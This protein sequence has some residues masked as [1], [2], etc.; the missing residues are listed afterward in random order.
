M[1]LLHLKMMFDRLRFADNMAIFLS[2]AAIALGAATYAAL[3]RSPFFG[4]DLTTVRILLGLDMMVLLALGTLVT[5]KIWAI[6]SR[7]RR[8][9]AASRLHIRVVSVFTMLAAAPAVLVAMFAAIFFYFGVEAWFSERVSTALNESQAVARAYL[10][11]HQQVLRADALSMAND[12][13]RQ[14][15][16]LSEDPVR[17]AQAVSAQAYLRSLTEVIVFDGSGK[18]LARSGLTFA[19]SFEPITDEMRERARQGEVVLVISDT[20][21]RV[22]ALVRLDNFVDTYLFV[23]RL[24]EPKVLNHME[25]TEKAVEEYRDL[26][27][28]SSGIRVMI[29]IIFVIVALLL[30]LAAVWFGLSF[31]NTLVRPISALIGATNRVRGGDLTARVEE[32]AELNSDDELELLGRGFNRM[33]QQIESQRAELMEANRQLDLRRRFTEAVLSGVSAGVIGLDPS[34]NITMMNSR[35]MEFFQL[36]NADAL[37]GHPLSVLSPEIDNH[38]RTLPRKG[39]LEDGQVEIRR[40]GQSSRTILV[41]LSSELQGGETSGYVLT[42][43][44]VS[45]LVNAQRKAAWA[46]V[47][48]RIAHEI[49]NP[50]TPIQL[51]AERLRRKYLKEIT[52]DTEVFETCTDTIIRHVE[53]IGRMVDE[54][55]AFARMPVPVIKTQEL[56]ELCRQMVFLQSSSRADITYTQSLPQ[57]KLMADCDGRQMAQALTNLLKNAAEAIDGR[58]HAEGEPPLPK[59]KINLSLTVEGDN[60]I[61]AVADNGRGLPVDQRERLTEPYVTTRSKGTGLGLAIVKK[62]MEDHKGGVELADNPSGGAVVSLIW[63]RFQEVQRGESTLVLEESK[64]LIA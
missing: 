45:E 28:H 16:R 51:S 19:L 54:F 58:P 5:Q 55:S 13:N 21:D 6:W 61:L 15:V 17:L 57:E 26:K 37:Q 40:S 35:A 39:K 34:F 48:R 50:L 4:N 38:L 7:R 20:D 62:I 44:D 18:I 64:N 9:Q 2:F 31:A 27:A 53:D 14:A 22:R 36:T 46:D 60:V 49:K 1:P 41:R 47:A 12:L 11:E 29:T 25:T 33:T 52:S 43:D 56:R 24:V 8:N 3:T 30:L 63:P 42:F 32:S 10:K 59:G 23:G